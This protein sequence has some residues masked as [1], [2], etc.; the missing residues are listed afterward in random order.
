MKTKM[1]LWVCLIIG[2]ALTQVSAQNGKD[3]NGSEVEYNTWDTYWIPVY[4][5]GEQVDLLTG[6]VI[7]HHIGHYQKG[8][9]VWGRCQSF[10]EVVS[11]TG[12]P[13]EVFSVKEIA[14]DVLGT[15]TVHVNLQGDQGSHYIASFTFDATGELTLVRAVCPGNE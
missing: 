5:D 7:I 9:W 6:S 8:V 10:G 13:P 15:G 14:N 12:D 1:F 11:S 4:C 3:G 2:M